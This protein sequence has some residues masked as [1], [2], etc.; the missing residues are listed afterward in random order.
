MRQAGLN[1][2]AADHDCP[3][4]ADSRFIRTARRYRTNETQAGS[5][6]TPRSSPLPDGPHQAIETI[7]LVT[8]LC[9]NLAQPGVRL[10]PA[11]GRGACRSEPRPHDV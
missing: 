4:H 2:Q 1:L 5:H 6:T 7:A 8:D 3:A 9:T 11:A 10:D